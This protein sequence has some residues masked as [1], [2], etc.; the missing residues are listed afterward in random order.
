[1]M[2]NSRFQASWGIPA[3]GKL[4]IANNKSKHL[5]AEAV[6]PSSSPSQIKILPAF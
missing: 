4:L 6:F 3:F 2:E 1:M 5:K